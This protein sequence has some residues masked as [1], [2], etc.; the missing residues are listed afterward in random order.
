MDLTARK[1]KFIKQFMKIVSVEKLERF[2]EFLRVE[3]NYNKNIVAHT[4]KENLLHKTSIL[5]IIMMLLL[6][7]KRVI[8]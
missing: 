7:I 3:T 2:E 6:H 1:N 4:I 5:K 8:F